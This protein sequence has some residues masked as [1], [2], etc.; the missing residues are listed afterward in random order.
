MTRQKNKWII[1]LLTLSV[2]LMIPLQLF[3]AYSIH[4]A[5][6]FAVTSH[7]SATHTTSKHKKE[8]M[9][10]ISN[11]LIACNEHQTCHIDACKTS[12]SCSSFNSLSLFRQT[13]VSAYIQ[14]S[15][16]NPPYTVGY[17]ADITE[18]PLL[19]PPISF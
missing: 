3:A 14:F 15:Q 19:R 17:I 9:C 1:I 4:N 5:S 16:E 6:M 10:N 7:N 13:S 12:T 8:D 11:T 2:T 18:N